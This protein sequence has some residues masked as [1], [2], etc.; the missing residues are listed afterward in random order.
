M[1]R[2]IKYVVWHTL[3]YAPGTTIQHNRSD[4]TKRP[5]TGKHGEILSAHRSTKRSRTYKMTYAVHYVYH[6]FD[7]K[8]KCD[9]EL[10]SVRI[11]IHFSEYRIPIYGA[12]VDCRVSECVRCVTV[13]RYTC[14][15]DMS[16]R[17][18]YI[19][20]FIYLTHLRSEICLTFFSLSLGSVETVTRW[21]VC[22]SSVIWKHQSCISGIRL[23]NHSDGN[24]ETIW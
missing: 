10:I 13:A 18:W 9:I 22:V 8:L 14:E 2:P 19:C 12:I 6:K 15:C 4:K 17:C 21:Q 20:I 16:L 5:T 7:A 11:K 3:A 23:E 24:I 1:C